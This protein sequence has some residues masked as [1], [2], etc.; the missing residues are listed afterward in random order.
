MKRSQKAAARTP[1]AGVRVIAQKP[2]YTVCALHNHLGDL[3]ARFN[4]L[5]DA[6]TVNRLHP[7]SQPLDLLAP[8]F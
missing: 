6:A 5:Q 4:Q 8:P 3:L 2:D 7:Q 1:A